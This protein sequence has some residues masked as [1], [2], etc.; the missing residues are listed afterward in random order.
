MSWIVRV[1]EVRRN[2]RPLQVGI[3]SLHLLGFCQWR[4]AFGRALFEDGRRTKGLSQMLRSL[5][6][7]RSGLRFKLPYLALVPLVG[8]T[9]WDRAMQLIRR[10]R[11]N[12][13]AMGSRSLGAS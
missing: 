9:N 11:H 4:F 12:K 6:E 5:L 3:E 13:N 1:E 2:Q 7:D 10:L 8:V